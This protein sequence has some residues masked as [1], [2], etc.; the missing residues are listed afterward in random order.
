MLSRFH[1]RSPLG[2]ALLLLLSACV[3]EEVDDTSPTG[4]SGPGGELSVGGALTNLSGTE[5]LA[6]RYAFNASGTV[7][8]TTS[9]GS[10]DADLFIGLGSPPS[11][12]VFACASQGDSNNESCT[13]EANG[14]VHVMVYGFTSYSGVRLAAVGG[15]GGGGGGGGGG[16]SSDLRCPGSLPIGYQCLQAG[17]TQA[18]AR[19]DLPVLHGTWVEPAFEVCM[20]LNSSGTSN[21]RY[22]SGFPP[23]SGRWGALVSAAGQLLPNSGAFY[24]ATGSGDSQIALLTWNGS[25]FAGYTFQRRACPW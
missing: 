10:G 17:S 20:T 18:P 19:Y 11:L 9:G 5:G 13:V 24:V 3:V 2:L 1:Q 4:P 12:D 21:F 25:G 14:T 16:G 15:S 7:T 8:I 6:R 22:R 23:E